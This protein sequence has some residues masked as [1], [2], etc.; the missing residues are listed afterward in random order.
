MMMMTAAAG[1]ILRLGSFISTEV[2]AT[3]TR[4]RCLRTIVF[5]NKSFVFCEDSTAVPKHSEFVQLSIK[6]FLY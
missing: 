1:I 2:V 4:S 3:S 5:C 6:I